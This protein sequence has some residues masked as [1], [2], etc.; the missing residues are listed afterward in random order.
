MSVHQWVMVL[1]SRAFCESQLEDLERSLAAGPP[2]H[3]LAGAPSALPVVAAA[4][5]DERFRATIEGRIPT[6]LEGVVSGA[7]RTT[8]G[9]A[10]ASASPVS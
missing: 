7:R 8:L 2:R 9:H 3:G 6:V 1:E 5:P 10:L 4:G